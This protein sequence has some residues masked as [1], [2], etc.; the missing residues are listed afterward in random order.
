MKLKIL[1]KIRE[2]NNIENEIEDI[3][4]ENNNNTA[5][6]YNEEVVEEIRNY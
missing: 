5:E 4:N 1:K 6:D 3:E 2:D